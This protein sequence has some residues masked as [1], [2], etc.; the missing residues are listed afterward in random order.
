M[1]VDFLPQDD[2]HCREAHQGV[3]MTSRFY[4]SGAA[5]MHDHQSRVDGALGRGAILKKHRV[6]SR[7]VP[8]HGGWGAHAMCHACCRLHCYHAPTSCLMQAH[9]Q[10]LHRLQE[11]P[12]CLMHAHHQR[13]YRLYAPRTPP[14]RLVGWL[15][16]GWSTLGGGLPPSP[17]ASPG[18]GPPP[19][20]V[21]LTGGATPPKVGWLVG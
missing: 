2:E 4:L 19:L 5:V 16:V 20:F 17:L 21:G 10:R 14:Q 13:F 15:V 8:S 7:V 12:S 11:P 9:S 6:P 18:Q 1:K 3:L